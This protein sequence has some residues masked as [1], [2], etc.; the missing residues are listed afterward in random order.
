[1]HALG[2]GQARDTERG[3]MPRVE[4]VFRRRNRGVLA[5]TVEDAGLAD[6]PEFA[7]RKAQMF[8]HLTSAQIA[9]LQTHASRR[10][11]SKGEILSEPGD[12]N[13]P[14]FVV[15]SGSIEVV[16]SGLSGEVLVVVHTPGSFTGEMT[17]TAGQRYPGHASTGSSYRGD[18]NVRA[19]PGKLPDPA[20]TNRSE[21][22]SPFASKFV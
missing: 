7:G 21:P 8:P 22:L 15:L 3:R 16:Q 11:I 17:M 20:R 6:G 2:R 14:M 19:I 5:V 10:N 18:G 12:R 1:M 4:L 13:R 9:R